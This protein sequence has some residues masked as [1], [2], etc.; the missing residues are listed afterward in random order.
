MSYN[1]EISKESFKFAV[2]HFAI[3]GPECAERLH[4]HNYYVKF[5]LN[6]SRTSEDLGMAVEF[7][8]IKPVLQKV[9][10]DLDEYILIPKKSPFLT[11]SEDEG[12]VNVTFHKKNY[13]FPKEDVL[14]LPLL[15]IS[16]EELSKY[17]SEEVY[18]SLSQ[19][20]NLN[21]VSVE[22][23]EVRG[24]KVTFCKER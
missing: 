2:S 13:S 7:N 5:L 6:Y 8:D 1:L 4:G 14:F 20:K 19:D 3:F 16:C 24:Q 23:Q 15:N 10:K 12:Q 17:L 22:V 21:S 18:N 9:C 11:I